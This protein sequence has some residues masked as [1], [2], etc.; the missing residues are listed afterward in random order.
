MRQV[1]DRQ[2][3][4]ARLRRATFPVYFVPEVLTGFAMPLA[5]A[6]FA[7]PAIGVDAGVLVT[8][9]I[10]VW[11]LPEA[12]L[13]RLAHWP[14]TKWSPLAWLAR[15]LLVPVV[16]VVAWLGNGF[17]WRGNAMNLS[18]AAIREARAN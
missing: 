6:A 8:T 15:D 14:F 13:N 11:Y 16:W 12:L 17:A 1:W 9:L 7:T 4:W 18:S 2:L 5:A 3:R 10:A